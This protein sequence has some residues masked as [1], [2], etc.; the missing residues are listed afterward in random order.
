MLPGLFR[1]MNPPPQGFTESLAPLIT[2]ET[3]LPFPAADHE[4]RVGTSQ[5]KALPHCPLGVG[6]CLCS[7]AAA[8]RGPGAGH[9]P[10]ACPHPGWEGPCSRSRARWGLRTYTVNQL[11]YVFPCRQEGPRLGPSQLQRPQPHPGL[12]GT[13]VWP[14]GASTGLW[15]TPPQCHTPGGAGRGGDKGHLEGRGVTPFL[16]PPVRDLPPADPALP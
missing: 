12:L 8:P 9:V 1:P 4:S 2:L 14:P 10:E 3:T 11:D 7:Q 6:L 13:S 5:S 16:P 15:E